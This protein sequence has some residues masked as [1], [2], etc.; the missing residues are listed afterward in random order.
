MPERR[1]PTGTPNDVDVIRSEALEAFRTALGRP[2]F[3]PEERF[4]RSGGD[5][6]TVME[7][8][9]DLEARHGVAISAAEFMALDSAE[10]L[11]RHIV[12]RKQAL[13]LDGALRAKGAEQRSGL[14]VVQ[15][16]RPAT[17][18]VCVYGQSGGSAYAI[19]LAA[20]L[21]DEQP[22]AAIYVSEEQV[23]AEG[24]RPLRDGARHD[25]G[26][27]LRQY[28]GRRCVPMGFSLGA[29]VALAV[30]HELA[31][32]GVSPAVIVVL[33]D[34]AD[35]DRRHFGT[36]GHEADP[37]NVIDLH[38][39]A[40]RRSPAEPIAARIVYFRS[41]S[42]EAFFR[43]DPTRGWGEIATDGVTP[44]DVHA[45]HDEFLEGPSL[46]QIAPR[47]MDEIAKTGP[48]APAPNAG[49]E[50][51]FQVRH[52]A[53][54]GDLAAEI[55]LAESAIR[56]DAEQ[57]AWLYANLAEALF[58]NDDAP[59]ALDAL[60]KARC[61]DPWPLTLDLRFLSEFK[62][63]GL[64][65][66]LE[67][68][69]SRL[70]GMR[71]DHPSVSAQM[72]TAYLDLGLGDDAVRELETGLA[73]A[74]NDVRLSRLL[75]RHL[76]QEQAWS[77]LLTLS[78]RLVAA[79]PAKRQFRNA[80]I[81]ASLNTGDPARALEFH[82]AITTASPPDPEG[83]VLLA[84]ALRRMDRAVEALELVDRAMPLMPERPGVYLLRH[85]CLHALG[86]EEEAAEAKLRAEALQAQVAQG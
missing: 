24:V 1:S 34:S 71:S 12:E 3:G 52:A 36:L 49:Q 74:P 53:R 10:L 22:L 14:M 6:L 70:S 9:L 65:D 4:L 28:P 83:L 50:L 61:R 84:R 37:A 58:Q 82:D 78:E 17:P 79:Y 63:R 23:L 21:P 8:I 86:R 54:S 15:E 7:V 2:D 75:V 5:S 77:P 55:A 35:L 13:G 41:D 72:A 46:R 40:L 29:H 62:R 48:P 31:A 67:G 44:I 43:S 64:V 26:E 66:E 30:S 16:G 25:A 42:D 18:L 32:Q 39:L 33:D 60:T 57:P 47:L 38:T 27:I 51:R 20:F 81:D 11:A 59:A 19:R 85:G 73:M 69:V 68:V 76:R 56:Q 80:L 45:G